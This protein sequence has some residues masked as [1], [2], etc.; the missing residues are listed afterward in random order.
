MVVQN[1]TH[2]PGGMRATTGV[3]D[4][5][6][7]DSMGGRV[8]RICA[9]AG[10]SPNSSCASLSVRGGD[11]AIKLFLGVFFNGHVAVMGVL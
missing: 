2:L 4:S 11:L 10:A 3:T 8:V 5:L 9:S 1:S 6:C 7:L